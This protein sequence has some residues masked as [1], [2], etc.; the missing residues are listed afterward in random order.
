M[1]GQ[2][3]RQLAGVAA[4]NGRLAATLA[5]LTDEQ[6]REPS[7]LPG[8]T[9][10]HVLSHIAYNG[11]GL[12]NLLR[13]ARTGT[14]TP[15]YASA[16]DRTAAIEEGAGRTAAAL[17][18]HVREAAAQFTA[19]AARVAGE[20]WSTPVRALSGPPFPAAGVP[21]RRFGEVEIHHAD[22]GLAYQPGDWPEEFVAAYFPRVVRS[23]A[24]RQDAPSCQVT[25]HGAGESFPVGPA[26]DGGPA[27]SGPPRA[28]LAWLTGRSDGAGLTV[29]GAVPVPVLPAWR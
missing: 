28:L 17:A 15:M 12:A 23:W 29:T 10:G 2:I 18:A 14:E 21:L 8:W 22:L 27:V 13:W 3:R 19:E 16:G 4:A 20:A 9:R 6:A 1:D 7:L 5:T 11:E 26:A 25:P 24:G